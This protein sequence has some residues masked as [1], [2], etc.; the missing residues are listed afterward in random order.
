MYWDLPNLLLLLPA[1]E[2]RLET[3]PTLIKR[4]ELRTPALLFATSR[5]ET[6]MTSEMADTME[7]L[8]V[9]SVEKIAMIGRTADHGVKMLK[10]RVGQ[11]EME[12]ENGPDGNE[13]P[14][15]M[16]T[17]TAR[18]IREKDYGTAKDGIL[19]ASLNRHGF[20]EIPEEKRRVMW[21]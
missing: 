14:E 5:R 2:M 17:Q 12:I 6:E 10:R 19:V 18:E 21:A 7:T 20:E 13:R 1:L 11:E 16:R 15:M 3:T 8:H 9:G 4:T